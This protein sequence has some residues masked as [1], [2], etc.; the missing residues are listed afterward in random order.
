MISPT[1]SC[2]ALFLDGQIARLQ[3]DNRA[4][5]I[6]AAEEKISTENHCFCFLKKGA[7]V[8]TDAISCLPLIPCFY[9][10]AILALPKKEEKGAAAVA[11]ISHERT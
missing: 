11:V 6:A 8:H 9:I 3:Q 10:M 5:R 7:A 2:V 1:S 4:K